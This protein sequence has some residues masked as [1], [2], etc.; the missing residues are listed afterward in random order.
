M[1]FGPVTRKVFAPPVTPDIP[2]VT[3]T[4]PVQGSTTNNSSRITE[5]IRM[6]LLSYSSTSTVIT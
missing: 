4:F 5:P 6:P 2:L 3:G 1:E